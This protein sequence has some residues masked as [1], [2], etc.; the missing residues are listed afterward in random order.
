[1]LLPVSG[2][3][4]PRT[5]HRLVT[6]VVVGRR[7][8]RALQEVARRVVEEPIFIG[9]KTLDDRMPRV[10]SMMAGML[11]GRRVATTDVAALGAA[12]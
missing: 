9:F 8:H 1:V 6:G 2:N 11:G 3:A 10:G 12:T 5:R 7:Q 4:T